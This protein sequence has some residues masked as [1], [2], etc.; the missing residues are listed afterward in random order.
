MD[1][2]FMA[3]KPEKEEKKKAPPKPSMRSSWRITGV[4]FLCALVSA[5]VVFLAV[6]AYGALFL[7]EQRKDR[8]FVVLQLFTA[9]ITDAVITE[10][11]DLLN[12]LVAVAG[13]I[14][15][16]INAIK[17]ENEDHKILSEWEREEGK[18]HGESKDEVYQGTI[19]V[20]DETFGFLTINY[21]FGGIEKQYRTN[22]MYLGG[23]ILALFLSSAVV[24]LIFNKKYM[25]GAM[26]KIS[27][28]VKGI[29]P[30]AVLLE[31][32]LGTPKD[33]FELEKELLRVGQMAG[34]V[35]PEVVSVE[36]KTPE[37]Q[38]E[39]I[40]EEKIEEKEIKEETP[41]EKVEEAKVSEEVK[42]EVP[43]EE[44]KVSEEVKVDSP[45]EEKIEEA[46]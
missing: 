15:P 46:K 25:M 42:V 38:K 13:Q 32:G 26:Q 16:R 10:E 28:F 22:A 39:K 31:P 4:I 3:D 12:N 7:H 29:K 8:G 11:E 30:G 45:P 9:S 27:I 35:L 40:S 37:V 20:A 21:D 17:I 24:L 33:L 34:G 18:N 36:V 43:A 6:S 19:S 14:E 1:F 5:V 44:A 23:M 41:E 2:L